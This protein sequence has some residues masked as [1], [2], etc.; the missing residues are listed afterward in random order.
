M[1]IYIKTPLINKSKMIPHLVEHCAWHPAKNLDK[2]FELSYWLDAVTCIDYSYFEF[3]KRVDYKE[4]IKSLI[5]PITEKSFLYEKGIIQQ[6][7]EDLS[8]GQKIYEY[9]VKKYFDSDFSMNQY[10]E[11]SRE[12]VK[13]YHEKYYTP[14]NMI[15]VEDTNNYEVIQSWFKAEKNNKNLTKKISKKSFNFENDKYLLYIWKFTDWTGYWEM[16]FFFRMICFFSAYLQRWQKWEYYYIEPCF[17]EYENNCI[18]IIWD[19]DYSTLDEKFFEW[20]KKYI[21]DMIEKG[22]YF[23]ERF[24]LNEYIYWIPKTR[25]DVIDLYK[26][27]SYDDFTHYFK[28]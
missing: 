11:V 21:I 19:Y 4:A 9:V 12:D 14:E 5:S 7:L 1:R 15:V 6:E 23:K 13:N 26:S 16:Y 25:E 28:R 3:D 10:E 18:V 8:Y 22:G 2:Y 20:W 27:Y 17:Y 24:F